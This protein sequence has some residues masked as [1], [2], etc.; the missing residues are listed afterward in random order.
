MAF[1]NFTAIVDGL[2]SLNL[3]SDKVFLFL[4]EDVCPATCTLVGNY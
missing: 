2:S 3:G 1:L 4:F